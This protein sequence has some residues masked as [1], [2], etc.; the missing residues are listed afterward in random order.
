MIKIIPQTDEK[1]VSLSLKMF[2]GVYKRED[3]KEVSFYEEMRFID[4]YRFMNMSLDKLVSFLPVEAFAILDDHF[5]ASH[6]TEEIKLLHRKGFYPYSYA[7]SFEKFNETK[8]TPL[9]QW[10]DTLRGG[11]IS[12]TETDLSH[13]NEVFKKFSCESFGDYHDLY[14]KTDTHLLA[15]VF[16]QFR[17]VCYRTYR[18]YYSAANLAGDAFMKTCGTNIDLLT[19]REH[20]DMAE[21]LMR[22][23]MSSVYSSRLFVA[24]N[25]YVGKYNEFLPTSFG[26]MIDA[27]HLYG[28]V[29]QN[30]PLP[31]CD[32]ESLNDYSL[33]DI[34]ATSEE[35]SVGY[36]F[37]ILEVDLKYGEELQN[38]HSDFPLAP[39][40]EVVKVE[41]FSEYQ[42]DLREKLCMHSTNKNKKR[43]QTL[44]DKKNY[45]VHYLTLKLYVSLGLVVT[46]VHRVIQFVQCKWLAGYIELNSKCRAES[47]NKFDENFYK[48]MINS[49]YG[50]ICESPRNRINAYLVRTEVKPLEYTSKFYFKSFKIFSKDLAVVTLRK[51][52]FTWSKPLIIGASILDL[53]KLYMYNF[54][55][56]VMKKHLNVELLY[57]DKDSLTYKVF[58]EHLY[59]ELAENEELKAFFNFSNY[60]QTSPL[61]SA[62]NKKKV[63]LFKDELCGKAMEEFVGLKPKMYS[64]LA[65]GWFF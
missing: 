19:K 13:A 20:L 30:F 49:V 10:V 6:T 59:K 17:K 29:M 50:K 32:F 8:L 57:S 16:E 39:L 65:Q 52:Q 55:Y 56:N 60:P 62:A 47:K 9:D 31:Q 11:K 24:N 35:S 43:L 7:D 21:N 22:G 12:I 3:G 46:K 40:K 41:W 27:N 63:L 42:E 34:L 58:T 1:Y 38:L 44:Y 36:I 53:S 33:Q 5:S 28:G 61:Y 48:L 54:H 4:S 18:Q 26:L 15:A 23:G 37:Y 45:T 2:V 51:T 14:L 64:I 25:R